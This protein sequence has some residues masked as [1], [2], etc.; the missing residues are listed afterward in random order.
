MT[1]TTFDL[2]PIFGVVVTIAG[3]SLKAGRIL[4]T[5]DGVIN[6]AK[7]I[8]NELKDYSRRLTALEAKLDTIEKARK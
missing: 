3:I 7:E 2:I 6:D 1:L 4:Q 8:K 5:L